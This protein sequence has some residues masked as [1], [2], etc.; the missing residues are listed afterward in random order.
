LTKFPS[1]TWIC[2]NVIHYVNIDSVIEELKQLGVVF[3]YSPITSLACIYNEGVLFCSQCPNRKF[4]L[5][6]FEMNLLLSF[7]TSIVYS[8]IKWFDNP[9]TIFNPHHSR[10]ASDFF[11]GS[12]FK[13]HAMPFCDH[14]ISILNFIVS[15][16]FSIG[17][18]ILFYFIS[19]IK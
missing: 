2:I 5:I 11:R 12:D 18:F 4:V 16:L 7:E 14:S 1:A 17:N 8:F 13:K 10:M 9:S 15:V 3:H 6:C 19:Y